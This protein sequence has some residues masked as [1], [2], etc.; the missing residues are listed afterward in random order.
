MPRQSQAHAHAAATVD[1]RGAFRVIFRASG[2]SPLYMIQVVAFGFCIAGLG[3]AWHLGHAPR[4]PLTSP[5]AHTGWTL[6][7]GLLAVI[8]P[9]AAWAY[10]RRLAVELQLSESRT[11]RVRDANL[12]GSSWRTISLDDITVAAVTQGDS[13]GES[14][15]S[16][17]RV[18][19]AVRGDRDFTVPLGRD[20][21]Q[22][23]RLVALLR[24]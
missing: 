14:S 1:G 6:V 20:R 23:E 19:V 12:L 13:A 8:S 2:L 5:Q 21:E 11:L 4:H 17:S 7:L 3:L 22:G 15:V 16:P 9:L 10:G 18:H 24:G